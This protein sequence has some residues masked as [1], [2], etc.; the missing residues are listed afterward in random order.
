MEDLAQDV[1]T[2]VERLDSGPVV[3]VGL[4]QGAMVFLIVVLTRPDL[5]RGLVLFDTSA[6]AEQPDRAAAIRADA[7]RLPRATDDEGRPS[8]ERWRCRR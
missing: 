6:R 2:M 7:A 5:V 4:S 3:L 8:C 1:V